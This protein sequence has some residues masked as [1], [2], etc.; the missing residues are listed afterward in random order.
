MARDICNRL[1]M[2][3]DDTE[4]ILALV[5]NHM[6]FA[7]TMKMRESTLKR[8]MRLPNFLEHLALHKMDCLSSHADLTLY[9]FV[10]KKM[11]E[12]P[13]EEIRPEP[14]ITGEDLIAL[15][16]APGPRFKEILSAIEDQQLEGTL[17][18]RESAIQFVRERFPAP[19]KH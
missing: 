3:N 16:Y 8:F 12:T 18:S 5:N 17:G 10:A 7:D 9:D 15:G 4:Q 13:A 2:S 1:R 6:K 19:E 11:A 14:L